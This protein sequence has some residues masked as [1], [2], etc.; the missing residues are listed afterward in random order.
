[1]GF[2]REPW[3]IGFIV[4]VILLLFF[5][6]KLPAMARSLGQSFRIIKSEVRESRNDGSDE[7][8]NDQSQSAKQDKPVEGTVMP[9]QNRAEQG[10]NTGSTPPGTPSA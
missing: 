8:V 5:A 3:V 7:A 9:S 6:P 4:L 2:L 1:M 10:N